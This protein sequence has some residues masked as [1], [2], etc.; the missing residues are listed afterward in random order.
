[1][2]PIPPPPPP[3]LPTPASAEPK[4]AGRTV[5]TIDFP[6][7]MANFTQ[8][9]RAAIDKVAAQYHQ[10]PGTVHIVAYAAATSASKEQLDAYGAAL[11]RGQAVAKALVGDGVPVG[12]IQTEAAPAR[13]GAPSGRV[14][15]QLSP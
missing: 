7:A 13:A 12:K 3:S 8:A 10:K 15:I 2:A 14:V 4:A 11:E 9:D 1:M 5:A 6:A